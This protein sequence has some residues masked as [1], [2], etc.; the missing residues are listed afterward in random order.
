MVVIVVVAIIEV[1]RRSHTDQEKGVVV[2]GTED[3]EE[4]HGEGTLVCWCG[5]KICFFILTQNSMSSSE[6]FS[7][8]TRKKESWIKLRL[9]ITGNKANFQAWGLQ[10]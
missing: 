1:L 8:E 5:S 6:S 4:E 3:R 2:Q 9:I 7:K 10:R